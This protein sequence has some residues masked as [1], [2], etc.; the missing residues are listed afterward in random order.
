M[1]IT[2]IGLGLMGGSAAI[3]L[4]KRGIASHIIGVDT[5]KINAN[6][7]LNIG[8][9]D[10]LLDMESAVKNAEFVIVAIPVDAALLV[11]PK[12]LDWVDKQVVT[13]MCST[14][15]K[16]LEWVKY[17]PKRR[18]YVAAHPM[19]GTEFSG[20]WA[21][22]SGLFDGKAV[23]LCD[24]EDSDI[25]AVAT[26]KRIFETLN[27][28]VIYMNGANHDVH[29][30]YI[31]H[32]SHISSFA[33]ALTVLEKEKNEKHI[34]DLASGGFDSTVRLAKSSA[35]MW[36][37][38]FGQNKENVLTVLETYISK[39]K[40]FKKTIENDD[41]EKLAKLIKESN[42]IRRILFK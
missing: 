37:P 27:M 25:R 6:A 16:L 38:I 33:L 20:P 13:D 39:L 10:E 14:K 40:D 24:T 36:T 12:V 1:I 30:A 18:N 4:R 29:A 35:E 31:S 2:I 3:D 9:V 42:Q 41:A 22:I 26:T 34:F 23:I 11:L 21:A 17:H 19:A 8:F 7:A 5:D 28:R 15:G 32:I